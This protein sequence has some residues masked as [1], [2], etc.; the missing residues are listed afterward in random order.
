MNL[1]S[2]GFFGSG[3]LVSLAVSTAY[4]LN[5]QKSRCGPQ[6]ESQLR[7]SLPPSSPVVGRNNRYS[8]RIKTSFSCWLLAGTNLSS[9][10]PTSSLS[11]VGPPHNMA[12]YSFKGRSRLSLWFLHLWLFNLL[13][14]SHLIKSDPPMT[15]SLLLSTN[16]ID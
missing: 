11:H 12:L 3:V 15:V 13:L 10:K 1:L 14:R 16:S 6:Q 4:G 7:L 5:R 9:Q 2:H 8:S